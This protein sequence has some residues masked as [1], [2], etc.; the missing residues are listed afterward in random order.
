MTVSFPKKIVMFIDH[1]PKI[2]V[3][4]KS[5]GKTP[6]WEANDAVESCKKGN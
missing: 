6:Y 3:A 5:Y 4:I 2:F 1:G